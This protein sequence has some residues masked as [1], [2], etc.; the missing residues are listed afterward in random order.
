MVSAEPVALIPEEPNRKRPVIQGCRRLPLWQRLLRMRYALARLYCYLPLP[1]KTLAACRGTALILQP[2]DSWPGEAARGRDLLLGHF[3]FAGRTINLPD[4]LWEPAGA[5]EAWLAAMHGFTWLRDLRSAGGDAARRLSRD[6]TRDWL[7]RYGERW[8]APTW[9]PL[10]MA[11]RILV[12]LT[13]Y[14]YF[15]ATAEPAL[16]SAL[17][18]S[19]G[20]QARCL[21]RLLPAGLVGVD[22]L[23]A[24]KASLF[25][26]LCLPGGKG[27]RAR[28]ETLLRREL[29]R[30]V[31]DD[32]GQ[33]ER[34]PSR[35]AGMLR[36]LI[37]LRALYSAAGES[38]PDELELAMLRVTP[39][40]KSLRHGDGTLALFNGS[41]EE[42]SWYIDLLLQRAAMRGRSVGAPTVTAKNTLQAGF[43]RLQS[44]RSLLL[45]DGGPPPPPGYDEQAHAGTLSFEMSVGREHL[46]VNCGGHSSHS[47]LNFLL[48]GTAA[49]STLSV[50]DINSSAVLS[51]GGLG[52]RPGE[53]ACRREESEGNVWLEMSHDGYAR[54][55]GL[56]HQR[57]LYLAAGGDDLRGEDR[58]TLLPGKQM[59][60][61]EEDAVLRFHLH[62]D[63]AATLLQGGSVLLRLKRGG[64]W[65]FRQAG[66]TVA[67][68]PSLYSGA[69][70]GPPRQCEQIVIR[71]PIAGK[72]IAVKWSLKREQK[73][74]K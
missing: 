62:P 69:G 23:S 27:L 31:F 4:P 9:E 26:A 18:E 63:V 51:G 58:V 2:G 46:I 30:Q 53:V 54:R 44:G 12:C 19:L 32:G 1:Q 11:Q 45:V 37:D 47:D 70:E 38:A 3:R 16:Q 6:L 56:Q 64:G 68:E 5:S 67:L 39:L 36:D 71:A 59:G 33:I 41:R 65:R 74:S 28:G 35:L 72:K 40:L 29:Q 8:S 61:I 15:A 57:R 43:Q 21:Q 73:A 20:R 66:G 48:R 50:G 52:H 13:Q 14:E 22:L 60:S 49:H 7:E 34:S 17:I 24:I 55:L 25:A 10:I 42:E